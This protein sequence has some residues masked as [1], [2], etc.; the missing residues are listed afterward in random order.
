MLYWLCERADRPP[1]WPQLE[2]AICRNFGGLDDKNLDPL[3]EFKRRIPNRE[4][5]DLTH[6]PAEVRLP[7]A[8]ILFIFR[9]QLTVVLQCD[10]LKAW[11]INHL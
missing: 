6:I 10:W 4:D 8:N 7:V 11:V 9:I 5:P 2:H 1:T 3:E